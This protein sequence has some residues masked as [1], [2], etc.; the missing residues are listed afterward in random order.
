MRVPPEI[1]TACIVLNVWVCLTAIALGN[2]ELFTIGL[3]SGL[4]CYF[5]KE[6]YKGDEDE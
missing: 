4:L 5:S 2:I 3:A 6:Y 1:L